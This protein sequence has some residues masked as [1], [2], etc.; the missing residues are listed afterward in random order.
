MKFNG[1]TYFALTSQ[2]CTNN[3]MK[4]TSKL[5]R[6]SNISMYQQGQAINH[7]KSVNSNRSLIHRKSHI[8][9]TP[10]QRLLI[11][12]TIFGRHVSEILNHTRWLRKSPS[13]L[14]GIH[15]RPTLLKIANYL[16]ETWTTNSFWL[17]LQT[18]ILLFPLWLCNKLN[19][20]RADMDITNSNNR[21]VNTGMLLL[22]FCHVVIAFLNNPRQ[23]NHS[24]QTPP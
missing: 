21:F 3:I 5:A 24:T 14:R 19:Q 15:Q 23:H 1:S 4:S 22:Q 6:W 7:R 20:L 2:A 16:T 13:V 9:L 17:L 8:H 12:V 11:F 10:S 18:P